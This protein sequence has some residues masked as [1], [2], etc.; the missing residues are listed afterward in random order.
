[1]VANFYVNQWLLLI[2]EV[3]NKGYWL[4][5]SIERFCL[6]SVVLSFL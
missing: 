5:V 6:F 4:S 2:C 3:I 1:M